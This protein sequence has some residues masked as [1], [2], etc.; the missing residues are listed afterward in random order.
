MQL[1]NSLWQRRLNFGFKL[2][3]QV[4]VLSL[5]F[6]FLLVG[7]SPFP[8]NSLVDTHDI[9]SDHPIKIAQSISRESKKSL[10][11][12]DYT[13]YSQRIPTLFS[14]PEINSIAAFFKPYFEELVI[15]IPQIESAGIM[16]QDIYTDLNFLSPLLILEFRLDKIDEIKLD[17]VVSNSIETRQKISAAL[18]VLRS[19]VQASKVRIGEFSIERVQVRMSPYPPFAS[20]RI[21]YSRG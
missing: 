8:K 18:K 14:S 17:D 4:L 20:T 7:C 6:T 11:D 15:Y 1:A 3:K 9:R 2:Y 12:F 21:Q 13:A 19:A 5:A 10:H 16:L